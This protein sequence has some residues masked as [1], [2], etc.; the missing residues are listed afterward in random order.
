MIE[1][2]NVVKAF[3]GFRA[4][5]G[6]TMTVPKGSVYGLV[7]P[8]G[9]GKSTL[10]RHVTGIYRQ[11]SGEV[12]LEGEP[13]Y[14]N[15]AAKA[16]ISSIP[17]ELYYFL[18]AST[19]DMARFLKGFYPK[20]DQNRYKTLRDLFSQ[21]DEKR[22]MRRLSKGMQK[23][24]VFWLSL[25]CRPEVLVLDEPVDG[26]D[27]VMRR[28]VWSLI[29]ADVAQEGTTVLVSSHNLRELEDVCDRVGILSHGKVLIER[30]LTDLQENLVKMQVVFQERE[31]P[32]LPEDLE[33]LHV[34]QVGRIHTLIVRGNATDVTNRLA[35]YA[36]I[37]MEALP[38]TLEEIF[39][40]ELGGEDY[41][42]R[43]I[44]L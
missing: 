26:L 33:V 7:G 24:A 8:N 14:E 16:R 13:I 5:D 3:D 41:A 29:M 20:F 35:V 30:S 6:L 11:D 39:I 17:D 15:P 43:D 42:V 2:R 19:R 27:P 44:I 9:A 28:Q 38:L 18:S 23:Q 25:C 12:L 22:P 32:K 21:V 10:L 40:Y 34:S 1:A 31:L 4:L 36:P 37:L